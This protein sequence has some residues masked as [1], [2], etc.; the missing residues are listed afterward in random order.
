M[1]DPIIEVNEIHQDLLASVKKKIP[2]SGHDSVMIR[3][4]DAAVNGLIVKKQLNRAIWSLLL[5]ERNIPIRI[6]C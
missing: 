2:Q 6:H 4:H 1:I 3:G 5:V